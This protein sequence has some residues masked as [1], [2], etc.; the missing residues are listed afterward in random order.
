MDIPFT[1]VTNHNQ[2]CLISIV[3]IIHSGIVS[4]GKCIVGNLYL[5]LKN[6]QYGG[7]QCC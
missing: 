5:T 4:E 6:I 7:G 2:S 1:E 3:I